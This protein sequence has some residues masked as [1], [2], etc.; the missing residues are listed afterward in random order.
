MGPEGCLVARPDLQ[1]LASQADGQAAA[2]AH[3]PRLGCT[4]V[5]LLLV[6]WGFVRSSSAFGAVGISLWLGL[7]RRGGNIGRG[8]QLLCPWPQVRAPRGAPGAPGGDVEAR[9][10]ETLPP[11]MDEDC[12]QV[13][14]YTPSLEGH[15]GKRRRVSSG[16]L[17]KAFDLGGSAQ[18]R[19]PK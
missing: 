2:V 1:S 14:V 8:H 4:S 12:L 7:G 9:A 18:G 5:M 3:S 11:G 6:A 13:N 10:A 17:H 19:P 15:F 16:N